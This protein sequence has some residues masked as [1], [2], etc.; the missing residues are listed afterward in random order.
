MDYCS[1]FPCPDYPWQATVSKLSAELKYKV[2][3]LANSSWPL[4]PKD[5]R[6]FTPEAIFMIF[7]V[8]LFLLFA[9]IGTAITIFEY[10]DKPRIRRNSSSKVCENEM[11]PKSSAPTYKERENIKDLPQKGLINT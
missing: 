4:H 9:A 1:R 7:V 6:E 11:F 8:L 10:F 2:L 5:Q 3:A